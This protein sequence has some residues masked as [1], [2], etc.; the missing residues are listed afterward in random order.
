MLLQLNLQV[1]GSGEETC[2]GLRARGKKGWPQTPQLSM[3]SWQTPG[4]GRNPWLCKLTILGALGLGQLS[5]GWHFD[6][7]WAGVL[8]AMPELLG[9]PESELPCILLEVL[10]SFD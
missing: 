6:L 7:S 8:M 10:L 1:V 4:V 3:G 9:K 5:L 2:P